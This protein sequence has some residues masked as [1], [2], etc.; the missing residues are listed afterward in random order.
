MTIDGDMAF[1]QGYLWSAIDRSQ[2][3]IEFELDGRIAWANERFLDAV[4]YRLDDIVGRHHRIFCDPNFAASEAYRAF[5]QKLERGEFDAGEYKRIARDGRAVWLRATYNPIA[6][7]D[8]R[9]TR[10][11][12]IA[13][14]VT[15]DRLAA[16]EARARLAA[17]DLSQ[18]VVEFDTNGRVLAANDKFLDR[19]GYRRDEA[20]GQH[21]AMFC[22]A[23]HVRSPGYAAFWRSLGAGR[24]D[25][26]RFP[27][28][29]RTGA[30]VWL[31][32]T[33]TPILDA[34]GAVAKVVKFA[35]DVTGEV[36]L[37]DEVRLRLTESQSFRTEADERRQE[38]ERMLVGMSAVVET[39]AW[40]ATQ[41]NLLALNATIE[42][43]RA[44]DA[45]RGFGVV[46]AEVKKLANDTRAATSAARAM[47]TRG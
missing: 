27:R 24:F 25:T 22:D 4:G 1:R 33:Y 35:T 8:G 29:T 28:L 19:F 2:L 9:P 12:K 40:I 6:D 5:W 10:I 18:L 7:A 44:G 42:A 39:I 43:A 45:G 21:H 36:T 3:V 37:A 20:I 17:I 31:Q 14:D 38:A 41:T 11:V 15:A 26:G 34:N 47:A 23:G 16:D 32:A 13:S 30:T 46:A